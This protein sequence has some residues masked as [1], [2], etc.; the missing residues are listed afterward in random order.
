[1]THSC[2]GAGKQD[3]RI[4]TFSIVLWVSFAGIALFL[5]FVLWD[6][7][8]NSKLLVAEKRQFLA[9]AGF[10][11]TT[12]AAKSWIIPGLTSIFSASHNIHWTTK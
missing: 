4:K 3:C 6:M 11:G 2:A 8:S 5:N 12:A 10:I 9:Q 1:M 7:A